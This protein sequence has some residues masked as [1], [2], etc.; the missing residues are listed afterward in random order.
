MNCAWAAS[1]SSRWKDLPRCQS[2]VWIRRMFVTVGGGPDRT[3]QAGGCVP[4]SA[5]LNPIWRTGGRCA[6]LSVMGQDVE[7][8]KFTREDRQ[9]YREKVRRCLDVFAKML[10]ESRFDSERRSM[11]LEI[12]LNLTEDNG[13]PAMNN[14]QVLEMMADPDFQTELAQFN[15]EI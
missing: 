12:E 7:S 11:G 8:R 14:A 1:R 15:I 6:R 4:H 5:G 3:R 10:A 9:R 13:D 2:E